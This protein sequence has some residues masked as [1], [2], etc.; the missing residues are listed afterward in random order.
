MPKLKKV[1][2]EKVDTDQV[3]GEQIEQDEI[4]LKESDIQKF[5]PTKAELEKM[6]EETKH[7]TIEDIKNDP[8][9]V[10]KVRA[11]R[12]NLKSKRVSIEKFGKGLRDNANRYNKKV[13]EYEDSLVDIIN[14]EEERLGAL[15]NEG[16]ALIARESRRVKIPA[17]RERM[18]LIGDDVEITDEEIILMDANEFET[19]LNKR[20]ADKLHND[21]IKEEEDRKIRDAE[22]KKKMQEEEAKMAEER[23]KIDQERAEIEA[24]KNRLAQEQRDREAKETAD[25]EAREVEEARIAAEK[26]ADERA[27]A[28][29]EKEEKYKTWRSE[30]G[31]TDANK[32][33]FKQENTGDKIVLWQKVGIFIMKPSAEMERF[34]QL[35]KNLPD[36]IQQ[37]EIA[38]E[39]PTDTA[40]FRNAQEKHRTRVE[41]MKEEFEK[42][43]VLLIERGELFPREYSYKPTGISESKK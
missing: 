6:V 14:P 3:E 26:E 15:E 20:T 27:K 42:L 29:A 41:G 5:D 33:E 32:N 13:I 40:Q 10:E 30:L 8:T 38:D 43:R 12:I 16:E 23:V 25:R 1:I 21:R 37:L 36:E 19:Y 31:Y 7:I 22:A 11:G 39:H 28:K 4:I 18:A 35:Q 34:N 9:V 17:R 2:A 24:E